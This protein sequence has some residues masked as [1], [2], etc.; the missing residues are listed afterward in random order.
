LKNQISE[1]TTQI[2]EKKDRI[3]KLNQKV[4]VYDSFSKY[5][6]GV[7]A[8]RLLF[9]FQPQD[10]KQIRTKITDAVTMCL[11]DWKNRYPGQNPQMDMKST[12]VSGYTVT[13]T[14]TCSSNGLPSAMY[15]AIRKQGFFAG[16]K[17][18]GFKATAG[19][20]NAAANVGAS[21]RYTFTLE[22]RLRGGHA[23]ELK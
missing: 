22:L 2:E 17:Y 6:F 11:T 7:Q 5:R 9:D 21:D 19:E 1:Q 20:V 15:E 23:Y 12:V 16:A 8:A 14:F 10:I 18:T 13:A 3:T 4:A